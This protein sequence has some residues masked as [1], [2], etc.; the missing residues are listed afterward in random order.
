MKKSRDNFLFPDL[1]VP[2]DQRGW[3]NRLG[4]QGYR[5]IAGVDEAGRGPLAG[6]VVAAAVVLDPDLE[7]PGV[8]DSK[9]MKPREREAA[10]WMIMKRARDVGVGFAGPGEIDRTNILKAALT[11]MV[12][13]VENLNPEPDYLLIDGNMPVSLDRPQRS[14]VR[15]DSASLSIGAAS[16]VAKV[17]RDR[18][19]AAYAPRYPNYGFERHKGYGT[20]VHL[21]ALKRYGPCPVHRLTFN[22]VK[23]TDERASGYRPKG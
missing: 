13:A 18:I 8:T 22:R 21:E 2:E 3:E 5:L 23:G 16:I 1:E 9:K 20:R 4:A 7:Y 10:F 6:P 12:R 15:G 14:I 17:F 19:M 11:A